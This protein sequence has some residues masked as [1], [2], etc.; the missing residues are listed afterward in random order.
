MIYR[1][2]RQEFL[3]RQSALKVDS[4]EQS[5]IAAYRIQQQAP[6]AAAAASPGQVSFPAADLAAS[7]ASSSQQPASVPSFFSTGN[8]KAIQLSSDSLQRGEELVR[9]F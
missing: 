3:A 8:N 2:K 4:E 6:P 7:A 9:K 5:R 1:Q